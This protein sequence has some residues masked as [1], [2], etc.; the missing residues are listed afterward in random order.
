VSIIAWIKETWAIVSLLL[1]EP[2]LDYLL[3]LWVIFLFA[4]I[5]A[6]VIRV[7]IIAFSMLRPKWRC[8]NCGRHNMRRE[9]TLCPWSGELHR[10]FYDKKVRCPRCGTVVEYSYWKNKATTL[11]RIRKQA[12]VLLPTR[13]TRRNL[14]PTVQSNKR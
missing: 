8:P 5:G 2:E 6:F 13:I 3:A 11:Q 1:R 14:A 12:L 10:D 9:V 7:S 4:M